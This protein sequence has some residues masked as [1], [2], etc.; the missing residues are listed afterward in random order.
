LYRNGVIFQA[1]C[2]NFEI[3]KFELVKKNI[4]SR[5]IKWENCVSVSTNGA[6]SMLACKK[7]LVANVLKI[8]PNPYGIFVRIK[9]KIIRNIYDD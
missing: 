6:L 2:V 9:L 7:R 4:E 3:N 8:N 5:G 1:H